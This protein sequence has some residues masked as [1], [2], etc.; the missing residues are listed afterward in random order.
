MIVLNNMTS[1]IE[2]MKNKHGLDLQIKLKYA[3]KKFLVK[4][5]IAEEK[6]R[7]R[8]AAAAAKAAKKGRHGS[9]RRPP[10]KPVASK[11]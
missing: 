2:S 9:F 7:K 8:A 5:R 4:K 6:K 11:S 1:T 10:P 3:W